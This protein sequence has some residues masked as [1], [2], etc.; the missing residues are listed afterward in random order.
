MKKKEVKI[1]ITATLGLVMLFFGMNFLK[2]KSV[3]Q[4]NDV[5]YMTFNDISGVDKNTP[6]FADGVRV[7]IVHDIKFDYSLETPTT[8]V[9]ALDKQLRVPAGSSAAISS[10]IMGNTNITLLL[11][12]NMRERVNPGDTIVGSSGDG[13]IDR[14]KA[15]IPTIEAMG[16]K[17]DS[18]LSSLNQILANPAIQATLANAEQVSGN[19]VTSTREL[20]QLLATMNKNVPGIIQKADVVLDNAQTVTSNLAQVDVQATLNQVNTTLTGVQQT[21]DKLNS[22]EGTLGKL[23]NDPAL[24]NN[25]NATMRDADSL[26]VDLKTN[27]KRYVRFSIW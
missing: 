7:G 15:M 4:N 16:P 23:I 9:V 26:V 1:A 18:I 5:Y 17:L 22:T 21:V 25:L 27:P 12:N 24:Y 10:D 11:S 2:G 3:F 13:T 14:L 19:L 6:I 20:N 8:L